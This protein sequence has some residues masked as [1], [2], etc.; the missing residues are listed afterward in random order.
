MVEEFC[1]SSFSFREKREIF[2]LEHPIMYRTCHKPRVKRLINL[3]DFSLDHQELICMLG[4]P[5]GGVPG[6]GGIPPVPAPHVGHGP[7]INPLYVTRNEFD[8]FRALVNQNMHQLQNQ[9]NQI[10][11]TLGNINNNIAQIK[12]LLG[13]P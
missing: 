1:S 6:V 7:H 8:A 4:R 12:Q 11:A 3:E 5:H 13:I 9:Q 2:F 10:L